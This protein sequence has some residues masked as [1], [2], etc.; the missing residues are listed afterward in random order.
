M[1]EPIHN[2]VHPAD[3]RAA[4]RWLTI[5]GC[6]LFVT[7]QGH[8]SPVLV[9]HGFPTSSYD[10]SRIV[11]LLVVNRLYKRLY[12]WRWVLALPNNAIIRFNDRLNQR[13]VAHL[14]RTYTL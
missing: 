7:T 4:G 9:L 14:V 5:G 11:P 10:F 13:S 3:W 12:H 6:K 8:G 1:P 2:I